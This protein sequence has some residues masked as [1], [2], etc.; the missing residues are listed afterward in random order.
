MSPQLFRYGMC[1]DISSQCIL[2]FLILY[3]KL[4][5][6]FTKECCLLDF[7]NEINVSNMTTK[8]HLFVQ[9]VEMVFEF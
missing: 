1:L 6:F 4:L 2:S 9:K 3:F 7:K 8:R 5:D